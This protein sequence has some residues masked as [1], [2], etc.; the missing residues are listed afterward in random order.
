M[1]PP[2]QR[3]LALIVEEVA[4]DTIVY[5]ERSNRA[6]CLNQTAA[7]IWRHCDGRKSIDEIASGVSAALPLPVDAEIVRIAIR[8]LDELALLEGEAAPFENPP[9]RREAVRKMAVAG[10]A[11]ALFPAISSIVAPTPAMARSADYHDGSGGSDFPETGGDPG[12]VP[13]GGQGD[14][15]PGRGGNNPGRGGGN[16]KDKEEKKDKHNGDQHDNNKGG[17]GRGHDK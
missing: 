6:H 13:G 3:T 4:G 7:A 16:A 12:G 11:A 17:R 2:M 15:G 8:R 9:S 5:D 1:K 10:G 14:G